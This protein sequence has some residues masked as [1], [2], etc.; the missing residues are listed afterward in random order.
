MT[1]SAGLPPS[2]WP[3]IYRT[4]TLEE[5]PP[6]GE[7]A[8]EHFV[9]GCAAHGLLPLLFSS[10]GLPAAIGRVLDGHRLMQRL[11]GMQAERVLE[12]AERV[13]HL[14]NGERFAFLKG[15]DYG[16]RL[17]SDPR[18]R[19]MQDIDVLVP[20]DSYRRVCALLERQGLVPVFPGTPATRIWSY[21]Q[22]AFRLGEVLVE[23]HQTFLQSPRHR[24]DYTALWGRM[25]ST[26]DG[27]RLCDVDALAY[28]AVNL[29]ADLHARRLVRYVDLWMSLQLRPGLV[30]EAAERAREWRAARAF[31]GMLRQGSRLFTEIDTDDVRR[32]MERV[33]PLR[34]R[35]FVDRWLLGAEEWERGRVPAVRSG[36]AQVR[37]DGRRRA[38][39][40]LPRLSRPRRHC[41]SP[42][43]SRRR[44]CGSM[45]PASTRER[46][47]CAGGVLFPSG[48]LFLVPYLVVY[49]AFRA[50]AWPVAPLV[51]LFQI[52]HVL[53]ALLLGLF[54]WPRLRSLRLSDALFWG[55]LATV[56]VA[57]GAYLEFPSDTWEHAR[58][59]FAWAGAD[60]IDNAEPF[61]DRFMY[62]W[63][64]TLLG[65]VPLAGRRLALG[66]YAAGWELLL[67]MGFW[68]LALRLER[69]NPGPAPRSWGPCSSWAT[70]RWVS[71][72]TTR[73]PPP[74]LPTWPIWVRSSR[75]ST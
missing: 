16:R 57:P 9:G 8:A 24:V 55:A 41:R 29:A 33:L 64:F 7:P 25:E 32:A 65:G 22:R 72:G 35:R 28:H 47:R 63:G 69:P 42:D 62:F 53:N 61:G 17:Y 15:I 27:L 52:L 75:R 43:P 67:A 54:V 21:Y 48:W 44:Q 73:S 45:T 11:I 59:I 10:P 6:E 56:F 19:P 60:V 18:L 5:W 70:P 23:V 68:R 49:L 30:L 2:F 1:L 20:I 37:P 13:G 36:V 66:A 71:T 40:L 14:L 31:Y 3:A 4:L 26:T 12:A 58:R 74:C 34:E 50:A 39:R 38:P 51:R 46:L